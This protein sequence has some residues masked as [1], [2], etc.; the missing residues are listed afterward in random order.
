MPLIWFKFV[1]K[2]DLYSQK[3]LRLDVFFFREPKLDVKDIGIRIGP[4]LKQSR[5]RMGLDVSLDTS[6]RGLLPNGTVH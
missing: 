6:A 5:I 2:K 1:Y 3:G 4:L